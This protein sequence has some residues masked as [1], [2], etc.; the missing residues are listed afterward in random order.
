MANDPAYKQLTGWHQGTQ[1][2]QTKLSF[3]LLDHR[4]GIHSKD[5]AESPF[6]SSPLYGR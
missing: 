4:D 3:V 5:E 6:I 2:L 1:D